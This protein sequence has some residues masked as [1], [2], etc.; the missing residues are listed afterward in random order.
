MDTRVQVG[1]DKTAAELAIARLKPGTRRCPY[2]AEEIKVE[3][4]FCKHCRRRVAARFSAGKRR[5]LGFAAVALLLATIGIASFLARPKAAPSAP[6]TQPA[7]APASTGSTILSG[8]QQD[9]IRHLARAH[10]TAPLEGEEASLVTGAMILAFERLGD[11]AVAIA[12]AD[13]RI[14]RPDDEEYVP[15]LDLAFFAAPDGGKEKEL[16]EKAMFLSLRRR[17]VR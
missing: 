12:H 13:A 9:Y 7:K 8:Q 16:L 11:G 10:W 3:A 4:I 2:C 1:T 14:R 17:G 15:N 6:A 5:T